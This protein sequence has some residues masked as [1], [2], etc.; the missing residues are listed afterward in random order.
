[1]KRR[2]TSREFEETLLMVRELALEI[3]KRSQLVKEVA[4]RKGFSPQQARLYVRKVL[5]EKVFILTE[6]ERL[7]HE[8][9]YEV[10]YFLAGA[11]K[12]IRDKTTLNR[13]LRAEFDL[14]REEAANLIEEF[15]C[16]AGKLGKEE[17]V[18]NHDRRKEAWGILNAL[19]NKG[20]WPK[21][22][23]FKCTDCDKYAEHYH[24]PNYAYPLWIEPLCRACHTRVHTIY[25]QRLL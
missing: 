25:S 12:Y 5:D 2:G 19:I 3:P 16:D 22:S 24:H 6:V 20:K 11:G 18:R 1:M 23:I 9:S 14:T 13:M 21:A 17:S 4:K 7:A 15:E 8:R 10:N